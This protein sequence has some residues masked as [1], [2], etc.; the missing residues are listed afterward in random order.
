LHWLLLTSHTNASKKDD[1]TNDQID[2][3]QNDIDEFFRIWVKLCG[4]EGVTNYIH[5][6]AGRHFLEYLIYWQNLYHHSQQGWEAFN[7]FLK[8]FFFCR[9]NR[10]GAGNHG[11]GLKPKV[12]AIA[13]WISRRII[14]MC[15]YNYDFILADN[16]LLKEGEG[17]IDDSF[18]D[19]YDWEDVHWV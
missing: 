6:M 7:S 1:F 13:R 5:M 17:I 15:G 3:F 4:H 14:W 18:A 10:G 9:T 12:L 16:M 19:D 2:M 8:T 11:T